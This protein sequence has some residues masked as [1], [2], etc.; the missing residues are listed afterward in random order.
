M[1]ELDSGDNSNTVC[2][3]DAAEGVMIHAVT[4]RMANS[5]RRQ[6]SPKPASVKL[7]VDD[8]R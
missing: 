5:L 4:D 7:I 2:A 8:Q 6:A 1:S 3:D